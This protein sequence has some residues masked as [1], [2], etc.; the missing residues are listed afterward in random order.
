MSDIFEFNGAE[1][2]GW[3]QPEPIM[4]GAAETVPKSLARVRLPQWPR[5]SE[6]ELVRHYTWLSQRNFGIDTGFYPLGSCTMKHNP[7]INERIVQL[8]GIDR[9]HPLQPEHQ[10]QGLLSIFFEMQEMLEICSG[11]D[12]VTLQPVAGAQGEF[13]AIRCIQEYHRENGESHRDKVIVP[14]SAHGTNPASAA[15][16]GYEIIEIPSGDDGRLDLDALTAA[17]GEDTAAMMITNP[18]TLGIFEPDIARAAEIVHEVGGQMYYDGANF[19]AILGKTDPGRMGFDAVHYNLHKTFSQPHGGGGPGSGPIGVKSHLADFLPAPLADREQAD[20]DGATGDGYRYFW[21]TPEKSIGKVQQWHGNAGAVV[22]AWAFYRRYGRELELMSE[23]AVLNANYLRHRILNPD[24]ESR[25]LDEIHAMPVDGAPADIV[26]HE[27]TLSMSPL[28]DSTGVTG[29]DVAKR[30]L[31]Y[32]YM[33]PTLYF[34]MIVPECLMI[35][36][37][38]TESREVLDKFANDFLDIL[39]EDPQIVST[40]PHNTDVRRVDEVQAARNLVLRH[41]CRD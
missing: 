22:R 24:P 37:T 27:F 33:S 2:T 12:Q 6:P 23:H 29:K 25:N 3:S 11:M 5:A 39:G 4:E 8:P 19:N 30:L 21:R 9:I 32:G 31:D 1:G 16:C 28:K 41:P 7:R 34:P 14:D 40:A 35:E 26:K 20:G 36:P 38:E 15:M 17:V 13:A 18:S 10:I